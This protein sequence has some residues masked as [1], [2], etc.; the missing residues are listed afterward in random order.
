[1]IVWVLA[2]LLGV[3]TGLRIGWALVN[4]QS[5]VSTAMM[6]ALGSLALVAALNW[7]PLTLLVDTL[8]RWPSIAVALSQVALTLCAAASCV[9]ITTA[10][11]AKKPAVARRLAVAHYGLAAVI[12]AAS[13]VVFFAAGRQHRRWRRKNSCGTTCGRIPRCRGCCRCCT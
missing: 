10:A 8:L 4:K 7:P 1:M 5:I 12:A 6:L 11:S 2:G 3:A 9:M 13:L